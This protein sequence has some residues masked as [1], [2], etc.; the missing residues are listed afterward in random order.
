MHSPMR[1]AGPPM[2]SAGIP[3]SFSPRPEVSSRHLTCTRPSQLRR[4]LEAMQAI[5]EG[6]GVDTQQELQ[7]RWIAK[8][9][10]GTMPA[11]TVGY[12]LGEQT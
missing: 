1:P 11:S 6:E 8:W 7:T 9:T 4:A 12:S 3:L 10:F 5:G 2:S